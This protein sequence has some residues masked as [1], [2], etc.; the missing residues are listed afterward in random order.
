MEPVPVDQVGGPGVLESARQ[1]IRLLIGLTLAGLLLGLGL[2]LLQPT[3]YQGE[4]HVILSPPSDAASSDIDANRWLLNQKELM[5]S[6]TVT[7]R[8]AKL[9]GGRISGETL[10]KRLTTKASADRDLV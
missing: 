9:A 6:V 2:S 3:M 5:S 7:D 1:H 4:T 10:R 8:A